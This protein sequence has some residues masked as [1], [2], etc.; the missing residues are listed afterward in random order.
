MEKESLGTPWVL[1]LGD[2]RSFHRRFLSSGFSA[3][4]FD[5]LSGPLKSWRGLS[6][7]TGLGE[8]LAGEGPGGLADRFLIRSQVCCYPRATDAL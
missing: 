6:A 1:G 4:L 8:T 7:H 5:D 3:S 2:F